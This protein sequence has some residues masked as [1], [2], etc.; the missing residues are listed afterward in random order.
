MSYFEY[1]GKRIFY[2]ETGRGQP[3]LL[4]HGNTASS[5][6]FAQVYEQYGKDFKVILIDFLG[7]GRSD[8]LDEFPADLWFYEAGQVIAYLREKQYRDVCIIGSS[9]GAIVAINAA[10]EAPELVGK[11]IADSFEGEYANKAF[12]ETLLKDR[13]NAKADNNARAFYEYMHGVDWE[14]IVDNDTSAILR[15][16]NEI[17]RFFHKPL[18][19]LSADILLTGSKADQYMYSIS[20]NY[21]ENVYSDMLREIGHGDMYLFE[22]GGHPAMITRFEEFYDLSMRFLGEKRKTDQ[23]SFRREAKR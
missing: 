13:E 23:S 20:E 11:I 15:H 12:T 1:E 5:N 17:G 16:S 18:S 21:Y 22:E 9:G 19:L 10:L 8:R 3:L 14:Q 6:M 2:E 7:H 4:L